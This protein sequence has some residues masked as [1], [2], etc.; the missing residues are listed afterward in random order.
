MEAHE[1]CGEAFKDVLSQLMAIHEQEVQTLR[2]QVS[3]LRNSLKRIHSATICAAIDDPEMD[4]V[5]REVAAEMAATF[6][7]QS[8]EPRPD[9]DTAGPPHL[10]KLAEPAFQGAT[11][12]TS[13]MPQLRSE[14]E[15]IMIP[16][17]EK[18]NA[19]ARQSAKQGPWGGD[20]RDK[21][22]GFDGVI[23]GSM[24]EDRKSG[25]ASIGRS[26]LSG[27][28]QK[29]RDIA[30][31]EWCSAGNSAAK[32]EIIM[33]HTR[34]STQIEEKMFTLPWVVGHPI[35]DFLCAI[36]IIL[37]SVLIGFSV[38]WYTTRDS[39]NHTITVMSHVC[40][41]FFF[42]ELILRIRVQGFRRFFTSENR[43]WNGFDFLL[44]VFSIL[45]IVM[46][47]FNQ[48]DA[49]EGTAAVGS[50]MKTI[51]MLRIVRVF[52]VFRFFREL[53]LLALM[54]VDSMKSLMW[55]LIMLTIIIYVFAIW[56]TQSAT[57]HIKAKGLTESWVY[58]LPEVQRM[59]GSLGRTVYTL[60]QAMLG[61]VS[62]GVVSDALLTIDLTTPLLF[63]FYI[64]FTILAVLNIITGVFVDNAVETAKTQREFLVQKEMELK[65]KYIMEM[66][67][68]F[69]EMDKDGNGKVTLD[70]IQ[71][72][73]QDARVM[74]YF[75]ALGLDPNDTERLFSLIDDDDSGEI[76]VEEFLHG[77]LRLKG[78]A[79]S[80]DV[81][82][83][84]HHIKRLAWKFEKLEVMFRDDID[85]SEAGT[86][87]RATETPL[88]QDWDS[89][90]AP[91]AN[92]LTVTTTT[93]IGSAA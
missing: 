26:I 29:A 51:K 59:F 65:E 90:P 11:T 35:F 1:A 19:T 13:V 15:E 89:R 91:A 37:N 70:E 80:I 81:H 66:R 67:D 44:V 28:D 25:R 46:T 69:S 43:N 72:Y 77:C 5:T 7:M 42:V 41:C 54:I 40:N 8:S 60:I 12:K 10:T 84:I 58:G 6:H 38:Q 33:R 88:M 71:E 73:F 20:S 34:R 49:V 30:K 18:R 61:G 82:S 50:G 57:D 45:D 79:R 21:K 76:N 55:A 23:F 2:H 62:W 31:A 17:A 36:M 14:P 87:S 47:S 85:M 22:S 4:V 9:T 52:R 75:Q 53:S 63:F 83:V 27:A 39:E 68:L 86:R 56:F 48:G 32:R 93:T 74:S 3:Q 92:V 24:L 78:Q 16:D 64:A